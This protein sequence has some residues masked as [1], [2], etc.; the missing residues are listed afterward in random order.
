L[1]NF[2]MFQKTLAQK[3]SITFTWWERCFKDVSFKI[4]YLD[5]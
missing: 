4:S 1:S 3:L 5:I 2:G